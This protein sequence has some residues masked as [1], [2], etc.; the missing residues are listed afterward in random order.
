[1][2]KYSLSCIGKQSDGLYKPTC[3]EREIEREK[4]KDKN[5]NE[6]ENPW[7]TWNAVYKYTK[8]T[9]AHIQIMFLDSN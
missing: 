2:H 5:T 6:S 1:M 3:T 9:S 4:H 8:R 7:C